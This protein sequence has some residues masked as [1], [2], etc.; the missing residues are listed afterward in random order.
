MKKVFYLLS[1]LMFCVGYSQNNFRKADKLF[2]NLAY[3]AAA[4]EYESQLQEVYDEVDVQVY[5]NLADS[6]Y[7]YSDMKSAAKW[8]GVFIDNETDSIE[9]S[10][11]FK[12]AHAL[13]G[14][15]KYDESKKWM[16]KYVASNNNGHVTTSDFTS[17]N[18]KLDDVLGI[19]NF[20]EIH[21]LESINTEYSDFG[22]SFLDDLLVFAS[23]KPIQEFDQ[24]IYEWNKQPYLNLYSS[25][26]SDI[27]G[28]LFNTKLLSDQVNTQYHE[29]N[30]AH[31]KKDSISKIY[32]TKNNY[33]NKLRKDKKGSVN[34]KLFSADV[35][36]AGDNVTFDNVVE[37]PFNDDSYSVGHPALSADQSKLYFVSNMPGSLGATDIF[38]VEILGENTF[39]EP[40]NLGP[41]INTEGREM[42]PY[43]AG[44]D[45]YFSSDGHLGFGSLDIFMAT[46]NGD[47]YA[48]P[49]N[50]GAPLN[51]N[52]DD[53]SFVFNFDKQ[54]G[55]FSSNR[56][57]GKGDDDIYS[58][59][60]TL[61]DAISS[62]SIK[63]NLSLCSSV[64]EGSVFDRSNNSNV[65]N[66]FAF[67]YDQDHHLVEI[68]RSDVD[69]KFE[70]SKEIPCNASYSVEYQKTGYL[71]DTSKFMTPDAG[72]VAT[73]KGIANLDEKFE[74]TYDGRIKIGI[75]MINFDYDKS[76][77]RKDAEIELNKIV[78]VMN[79]Y[80]E[81]KIHIESHTDSRATHEYNEKLSQARA[82]ST[83]KYIIAQGIDASRILSA[84]GYGEN[85][86]LN[87][88]AD[89]VSCTEAQHHA[90]RRSEFI[91][92][93]Y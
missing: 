93:E 4:A 47:D 70:F 7:N 24:K 2:K 17:I 20:F 49:V 5:K 54:L 67:L 40:V 27:D 32:F 57:G 18:Q 45:L 39:S 10:Y 61:D 89:G 58:I 59:T 92:V 11:Y 43:I 75:R 23:A 60:P 55:Y 87:K 80:P 88:C 81:I 85:R 51:S 46:K 8:Y 79:M 19:R 64:V 69:G 78:Y 3:K 13:E 44:N 72:G 25:K 28:D 74:V 76:F 36:Y 22:A 37:L 12:Y 35:H 91:V 86:L 73:V 29:S 38:Y 9:S 66:V 77:I 71:F 16:L 30:V 84:T 65:P 6:Y 33:T 42:F 50:L 48:K 82:E 31:Y 21:N 26:I 34:L 14:V 63:S 90:N 56:A 53:F 68:S 83:R 62:D 41:T 1:S 15:K 52:M